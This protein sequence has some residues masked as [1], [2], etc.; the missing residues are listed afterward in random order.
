MKRVAVTGLG[1]ISS[2]GNDKAAVL[3]SLRNVR[4]G[5][6]YYSELE[7]SGSGVRLAG[8]VKGFEFPEIRSEGWEYPDRYKVARE[9]LRSMSPNALYAYCAMEQAIEDAGLSPDLVSSP[10]TGV[11]CASNG[12]S[13]LTYEYL[14][15]MIKRGVLRCPPL[16]MVSSI[17]GTVNMNLVPC[18]GIKGGSLGFSS[19]CS[20]SSHAL[21]AAF[22]RIHMGRQDIIFVAGAEDCNFHS[23]IPFAGARALTAQTDPTCNP[24]PFDRRRD[25][26]V[27]TG[28]ATVMVLEELD[29]AKR[30]GAPIYAEMIGWGEAS[31][32]YNV[33]MPEPNGEGLARAME[34]AI[35]HAGIRRDQ[36]DYINAHATSTIVGDIAEVRAIRAVFPDVRKPYVSSTKSITG[37]GLS[38]AGAMEAAFCCLAISEKFVPVSANVTELDAECA[39]VPIVTAAVDA[40]PRVA[41]SNS[42][43]FGGTNVSV[44]FRGWASQG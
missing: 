39:G 5:I 9:N 12:S 17:A 43:G 26:F 15:I 6:C 44:I 32:G 33:M 36:V 29:H 37:H 40:A 25:G 16:A 3:D 42:S 41:M 27:V 10:R 20:S 13:W 4:S 35:T 1:F 28:G 18:F 21:A 38:L 14:D 11:M 2:I 34:N 22:D 30:R 19:A 24:C 23:I 7:K 31:D 8:L